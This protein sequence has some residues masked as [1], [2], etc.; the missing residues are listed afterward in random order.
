MQQEHLS[1]LA[2]LHG[3]AADN[4][5]LLAGNAQVGGLGDGSFCSLRGGSRLSAH[6]R[7]EEPDKN[8]SRRHQQQCDE[9]RQHDHRQGV[10]GLRLLVLLFFVV[11]VAVVVG[12]LILARFPVYLVKIEDLLVGGLLAA[13]RLLQQILP[14]ELS[15]HI[16]CT[17]ADGAA[18]GGIRVGG[19]ANVT[20]YLT[21]SD[22]SGCE[23]SFVNTG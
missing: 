3:L 11:I 13:C 12:F 9:Y 20:N 6:I 5:Q 8:E 4:V 2:E 19:A 23:W 17:A 18:L 21:H 10:V 16:R 15:R 22:A 7:Q 14:H 1:L